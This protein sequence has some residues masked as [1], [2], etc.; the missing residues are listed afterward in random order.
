MTLRPRP[1]AFLALLAF[2]PLLARGEP[3]APPA[4]PPLP[5]EVPAGAVLHSV[6][7][8]GNPAGSQATWRT[9]D[10]RLHVFFEF[11]DRGRGP[12]IWTEVTPGPDGVPTAEVNTGVDYL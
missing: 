9:D 1:G 11:N 4:A 8:S 12:K 3:P 7:M 10:G 2:V 6:L 5:A